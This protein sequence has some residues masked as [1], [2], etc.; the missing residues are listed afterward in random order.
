MRRLAVI[1]HTCRRYPRTRPKLWFAT[2]ELL[3]L[4]R[5]EQ[6]HR[7]GGSD[8]PEFT[9]SPLLWPALAFLVDNGGNCQNVPLKDPSISYLS[10]P[11]PMTSLF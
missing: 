6:L 4:W 9:L 1:A 11:S 7:D 10:S 3:H 8:L 5:A 2:H